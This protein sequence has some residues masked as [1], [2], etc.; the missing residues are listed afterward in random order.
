MCHSSKSGFTLIELL[1]VIAI[2]ALLVSLLMPSLNQAKELA[3]RT[4]CAANLRNIGAAVFSYANDSN[5]SIP[6]QWSHD[7]AARYPINTARAYWEGSWPVKGGKRASFNLAPLE[8]DGYVPTAE[9]FYCPSQRD[10]RFQWESWRDEWALPHAERLAQAVYIYVGYMHN[11]YH[12]GGVIRYTKLSE[13]PL[14]RAM[15]LDLLCYQDAVAHKDAP[16]WTM[17]YGDGHVEFT[18]NEY[19]FESIPGPYYQCGPMANK[20][21]LFDEYL[22]DLQQ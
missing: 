20:W 11:P 3:K 8:F 17:L 19:V 14:D 15:C 9:M 5:G 18:I 22:M 1:V 6:P 2:I 10:W 4:V 7:D 21:Y 13:Y 12:N 16:G